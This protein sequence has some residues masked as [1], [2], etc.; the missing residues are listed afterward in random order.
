MYSVITTPALVLSSRMRGEAGKIISFLTAES[1]LIYAR[2]EGVRLEKS[3]LRYVAQDG[4][5]G[6][7]SFIKGKELYRLTDGDLAIR[8][9]KKDMKELVL[10]IT[11]LFFRILQGEE[12]NAELWA[13]VSSLMSFLEKEGESAREY[14]NILETITV[15]R[16]MKSLGYVGINHSFGHFLDGGVLSITLLEEA[17][18]KQRELNKMINQAL[19]ESHL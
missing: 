3:K 9:K 8:I 14:V 4:D 5:F 11:S 13:V 1:G 12:Q 15:A 18:L 17:K 2:A 6:T 19:K 10:R 7:Y 16:I